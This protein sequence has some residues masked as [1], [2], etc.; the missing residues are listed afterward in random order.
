MH[1]CSRYLQLLFVYIHRVVLYNRS[2]D[3]EEEE[4]RG[5]I[6]YAQSTDMQKKGQIGELITKA[7]EPVQIFLNPPVALL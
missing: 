6:L 5:K 7:E 4:E 2:G 3:V 1:A